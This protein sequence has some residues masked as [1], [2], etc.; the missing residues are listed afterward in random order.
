MFYAA[1]VGTFDGVHLGHRSVL[2]R[3]SALARENGLKA[4]VVTFDRHP[5]AG[6]RPEAVPPLLTSAR[7]REAL[8]CE[9][10]GIDRV[11]MLPFDEHLRSLT[12]SGFLR[13]LHD[14]FGVRL[15]L[16]GH[17][18]SFGSDRLRGLDAYVRAG[19]GVGVRVV[20]APQVS[21]HGNDAV[22]CSSS[23]RKALAESDIATANALLG[24]PFE[25]S[26]TVV[27]GRRIGHTIGFPTANISVSPSMLV[28]APGVYACL[29]VTP[30]GVSRPAM[31]NIGHNPTVASSDAPLSVEAN[32]IG[33]SGDLYGQTLRLRFIAFLRHEQRFP[34]VDELSQALSRD[35]ERVLAILSE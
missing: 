17:D 35:R 29:A 4:M 14:D 13:L 18:N 3:L 20:G 12:A 2:A 6:I 31:V 32:I 26:G 27:S 8:L 7:S 15:L 16:M 5:L 25:L 22:V 9:C 1:T 11:V 28:P 19:A 23:I 21:V 33:W 24:R 30:D 34:S 10:P